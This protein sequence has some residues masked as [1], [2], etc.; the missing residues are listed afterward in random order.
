MINTEFFSVIPVELKFLFAF[1][2]FLMI[3]ALVVIFYN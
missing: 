2:I 1:F 3:F